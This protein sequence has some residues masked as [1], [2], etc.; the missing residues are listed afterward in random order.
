MPAA[1]RRM[2]MRELLFRG[3]RKVDGAEVVGDSILRFR[4]GGTFIARGGSVRVSGTVLNALM[5]SVFVEVVPETVE[6]FRG[7]VLDGK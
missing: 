2:I 1:E 5:D 3:K 6:V 7:E 4:D